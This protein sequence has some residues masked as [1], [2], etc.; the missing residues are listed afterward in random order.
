M[1]SIETTRNLMVWLDKSTVAKHGYLVCLVTCL[2][3][4]AVFLTNEEYKL[5]TGKSLNVQKIIETPEVH[6]IARCGSS[7]SELLMHNETRMECIDGLQQSNIKLQDQVEFVD[8]IL[9]WRQ[10]SQGL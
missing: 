5:K 3:D 7:D 10:P 8:K 9:S 6:F 4:P 2:Y 1:R